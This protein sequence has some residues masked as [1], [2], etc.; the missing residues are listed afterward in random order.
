MK[1]KYGEGHTHRMRREKEKQLGNHGN[2][3]N[4]TC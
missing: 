4:Y 1:K 2:R 3:K